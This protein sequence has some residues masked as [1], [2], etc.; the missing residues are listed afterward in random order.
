MENGVIVI[1]YK[2]KHF[3][4]DFFITKH[5]H[6]DDLVLDFNRMVKTLKPEQLKAIAGLSV[7]ALGIIDDD[8][9][10]L[11]SYEKPSFVIDIPELVKEV[12]QYE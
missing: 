6:L 3:Y 9:G 4:Q 5:R 2:N 1:G 7:Y 10:K 12:K 8:T 11:I